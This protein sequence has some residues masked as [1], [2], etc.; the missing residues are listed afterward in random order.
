MYLVVD[1]DQFVGDG[2]PK[3]LHHEASYANFS[4]EPVRTCTVRFGARGVYF[5]LKKEY[6]RCN[7]TLEG[8][9]EAE[10]H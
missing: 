1:L 10:I 8:L 4:F 5:P 6:D 7:C 3:N 9:A 2:K